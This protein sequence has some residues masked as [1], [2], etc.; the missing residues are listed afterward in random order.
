MR[1]A[2]LVNNYPAV[3]HI[4]IRREIL[5]LEARGAEVMRI[6]MRGWDN[7][8]VDQEDEI[9]RQRTR[10][11]LRHGL[12]ALMLAVV[13]MAVKRPIA[14]LRSLQLAWRMGWRAERPLPVHLAYFAE[15]CLIEPWLRAA[16][17]EHVHAH[18]GTNSAEIAM[19]T[20][21][22]GGPPWSFT[23]HGPTEFTKAAFIGLAEKIR[24]C[25][26][27]VAI[28]S[29][30]RAQ[31][32]LCVEHQQWSKVRVVHC[33]LDQGAYDAP[34]RPIPTVRRLVCV[35]RLCEQKGQLLLVE[36]AQRL[37][38]KG[39]KFELVLVGDGEMRTEI[40]ELVAQ[41]QLQG[42]VRITGRIASEQVREEMMAA[43]ALVLASFGE[44]LP[45]VIMEAMALKRPIISTFVAGIPELVIA[46]EHGW[47]VPTGDVE[48]LSRAMHAC[49]D[50]PVD[51]L[52]RM[53]KAARERVLERHNVATQGEQLSALFRSTINGSVNIKTPN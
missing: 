23:V 52:A 38:A 32:Y 3:S 17:I 2:Y 34:T 43:R 33:G 6:A 30:G 29:Y 27:V 46:G 51:E 4:F 41:Q 40:E 44:G 15:A 13:R 36:A 7:L 9:E 47:L 24:R 42:V 11:V 1:I 12:F 14:A 10:Y 5:A 39:I 21:A 22:L 20:H 45:M 18:F 35:G 48:A 16:G 31:L 8:I 19:L 25:A 28:S 26:F 53:G 49:L 50:A 37:A